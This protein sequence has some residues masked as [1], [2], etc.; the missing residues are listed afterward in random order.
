MP[1]K[2]KVPESAEPAKRENRFSKDQLLESERFRGRKDMLDALLT[3][4][5]KYTISEAEQMIEKYMK[6][7]VK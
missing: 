1:Q 5:G 2:R 7:K 6:G 4:G 3:E